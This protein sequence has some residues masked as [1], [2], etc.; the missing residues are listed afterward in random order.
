[1]LIM[2][3]LTKTVLLATGALLLASG[4]AQ[5]QV[6][7]SLTASRTSTTL[8]DGNIVPMWGWSCG[9]VTQGTGT[10]TCTQTNGQPQ[11]LATATGLATSWQPPL[12]SVPT[13]NTLTIT[14]SNQLPVPTSLTIVGQLPNPTA[15]ANGPGN[16]T[17]ETAARTHNPQGATTWAA[18]VPN[19][20]TPP[21]Q[22]ARA[23][24][25]V[26]EA[27]ATTGSIIYTFSNLR[28]GTFLIESGSYPSIQAPM[29][30]YGV[31]VVTTAPTTTGTFAA[32]TAYPSPC[33]ATA[34]T[35]CVTAGGVPY[36]AD[37][38]AAPV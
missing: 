19:S 21:V 5:A 2:K 36:D 32:G 24:S 26:Q 23:E 16:P 15:D 9:A 1:M 34:S 28:P 31:L 6:A 11:T 33:G 22:G 8:P 14:L 25:F 4:A 18:V 12:I 38:R 29:G 13:G 3:T 17:R 27:A 37:G 20:F 35:A 7:L 30:L 10:A